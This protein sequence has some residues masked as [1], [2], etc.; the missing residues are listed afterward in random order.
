VNALTV[1]QVGDREPTP[2]PTPKP[3]P[4]PA[5]K[6]N[7]EP[8][9]AYSELGCAFDPFQG[10]GNPRVRDINSKHRSD[11][12]AETMQNRSRSTKDWLECEK[13]LH[14]NGLS[15]AERF[16]DCDILIAME[17]GDCEDLFVSLCRRHSVAQ[18][19]LSS[20]K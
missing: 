4:M 3:A 18:A 19:W 15:A 7:P 17:Q 1:Y 5:P 9:G 14:N 2:K 6:P 12:R 8:V 20:M 10:R 13:R 11:E 16:V